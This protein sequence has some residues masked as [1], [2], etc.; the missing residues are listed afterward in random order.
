[1]GIRPDSALYT[2]RMGKKTLHVAVSVE[3]EAGLEGQYIDMGAC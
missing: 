2:V 1:M 3:S